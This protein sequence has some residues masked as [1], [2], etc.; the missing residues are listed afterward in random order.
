[1]GGFCV[2]PLPSHSSLL[3]LHTNGLHEVNIQYC[4]CDRAIPQHIQLLRRRLYPSSQLNV[5]N[6]VTFELLRLLHHLSLATKA[7]TYDF[8]RGLERL[9]DSVGVNAPKSRYRA[10][11]RSVMQWR[12]LKLLKRGGRGNDPSG[13]QGTQNGELA[14]R[15]PSCPWPGI[16]LIDNWEDAPQSMK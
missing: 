10:L 4:G 16:N 8:Y 12:H 15:C 13:V 6:C 3:V 7:S 9:T 1:M 14:I 2:N 5:K 11:F